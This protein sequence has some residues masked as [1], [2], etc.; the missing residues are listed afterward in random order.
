M[1]NI[2]VFQLR[3]LNF[4]RSWHVCRLVGHRIPLHCLFVSL[5]GLE[6]P[7][8]QGYPR[9]MLPL[10]HDPFSHHLN[11]WHLHFPVFF[12]NPEAAY[13]L[14]KQPIIRRDLVIPVIPDSPSFTLWGSA[15]GLCYWVCPNPRET[16]M[17]SFVDRVG[18]EPTTLRSGIAPSPAALPLSYPPDLVNLLGSTLPIPP[19][20]RKP[21]ASAFLLLLY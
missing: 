3:L 10:H 18:F 15:A 12:I 7:P 20:K 5:G 8:C 14:K 11:P 4:P 17:F 19:F 9:T 2:S 13:A 1:A 21:E 6:P 16:P